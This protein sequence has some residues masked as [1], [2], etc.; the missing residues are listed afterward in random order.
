[1]NAPSATSAASAAQIQPGTPADPLA[2][3]DQVRRR[4]HRQHAGQI[5][6][7]RHQPAARQRVTA[8]RH[9][10]ADRREHDGPRQ[11]QR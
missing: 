3:V 4:E 5:D 6:L 9:G 8:G 11:P 2:A 10:A 7:E 1:M